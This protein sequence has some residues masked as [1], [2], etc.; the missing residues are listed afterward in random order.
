MVNTENNNP[1]TSAPLLECHYRNKYE[2]WYWQIIYQCPKTRPVSHKTEEHHIVPKCLGGSKTDPKNLC[3]PT[4]RQHFILHRLLNKMYL[5]HEGLWYAVFRMSSV[6]GGRTYEFLR[7]NY[8]RSKFH[9]FRIAESL[10]GVSLTPERRMNI[11]KARLNS[12]NTLKGYAHPNSNKDLESMKDKIRQVW[13]ENNKPG[14]ILL[15]QLLNLNTKKN[16]FRSKTLQRFIRNF[17][18]EDIV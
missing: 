16:G 8:V 11:S 10:R 5:D 14:D 7:K 12:S 1:S 9:N 15:G 13:I 3:Y 17:K 2:N 4:L 18:E 6:G